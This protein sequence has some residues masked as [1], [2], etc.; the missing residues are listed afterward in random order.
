MAFF[1]EKYREDTA[2]KG[3]LSGA[4][5]FGDTKFTDSN[6]AILETLRQ[7]AAELER[8]MAEVALAWTLVNKGVASTLVGVS[9]L[10]QLESNISALNVGFDDAQLERL[11]I[12]S[13]PSIGFTSGL[14]APMIRRMVFGGHD[15]TGWGE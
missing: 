3:R 5:P 1:R 13:A 14:T 15:V 8:P 4:N 6:W 9:K 2:G 11:N 7:V 10:S 12:A